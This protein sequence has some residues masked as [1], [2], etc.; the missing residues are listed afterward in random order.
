MHQRLIVDLTSRSGVLLEAIEGALNTLAVESYRPLTVRLRD[1]TGQHPAMMT[2]ED[3]IRKMALVFGHN[4]DQ[5]ME[6]KPEPET[7]AERAIAQG[8]A[9]RELE[10][11]KKMLNGALDEREAQLQ[12]ANDNINFLNWLASHATWW[13]RRAYR[14][15]GTSDGYQAYKDRGHD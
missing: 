11:V 6:F 13:Q 7:L 1:V 4:I 14:R 15:T 9:E 5:K 12:R 3:F 2:R 8:L 10:R